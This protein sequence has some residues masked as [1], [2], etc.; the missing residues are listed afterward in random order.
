M[1]DKLQHGIQGASV[2]KYS[3]SCMGKTMRKTLKF[4]W[5]KEDEVTHFQNMKISTY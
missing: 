2:S 5:E 1:H 4:E 3:M